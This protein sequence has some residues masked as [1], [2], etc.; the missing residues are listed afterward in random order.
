MVNYGEAIKRP[1]QDVKKLI[2][3]IFL[4]LIPIV[5]FIALGY[6]LENVKPGARK[7]YKL[8]EWGNW[9]ELFVKGMAYM[10]IGFVYMIPA[11]MVLFLTIGVAA[12]RGLFTDMSTET[13]LAILPALGIGILVFFVLFLVA[14]YI[15]PS[16]VMNYVSK[17]K[18][19]AAFEFSAITKKAFRADY[20][21]A[22]LIATIYTAVITLLLVWLPWIGTA[23]A[24]FIGTLT[25]Y[26]IIS[27]AWASS[28]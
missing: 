14:V 17:N 27:E 22:W 5:N 18:F 1:F 11:L 23:M 2:I 7:N 10:V 12:I 24:T 8:T 15:I 16:A 20:F 26:T 6:I 19:S 9:W 4:S 25:Y 28:K 13:F 21:V 3:G